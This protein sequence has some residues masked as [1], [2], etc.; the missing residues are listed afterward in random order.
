MFS[1]AA[2][3]MQPANL[4]SKSGL[5]FWAKGDG[6]T[7]RVMIYAKS[8]GFTPGI[9]TFV[10]GPEWKQFEFPFADFAGVDAH[11]IMGVIFCGGSK[12]GPFDF[13][14]DDVRFK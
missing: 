8:K 7:Y 1:P 2:A 10:A 9:K 5:S 11:G 12:P 14:I 6:Q 13:Q 4:S 3:P